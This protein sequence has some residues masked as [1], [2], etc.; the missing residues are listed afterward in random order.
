[1]DGLLRTRMARGA[2][3]QLV[4]KI[5]SSILGLVAFAMM[6]RYL[7]V[8]GFGMYTTVTAFLQFFGILM[9]CGLTLVTIQMISKSNVDENK[10]LSNIMTFRA[11]SAFLFLAAAP[12]IV[13]FFPYPQIVKVGVLVAAASFFFVSLNQIFVSYFQKALRLIVVTIA[14]NVARMI[15]IVG[16]MLAVYFDMGLLNILGWLVVSNLINL[17]V[18]WFWGAKWLK[19]RPA[20]DWII[21][22]EI[23]TRSWPFALSIS[24]NLIYLKGDTIILSLFRP[25]A[26]VGLYGATY[27]V[28][29]ILTMIPTLIMGVA[30]P[31]LVRF[32]QENKKE[33]FVLMQKIFDCFLMLAVPVV[34]GTMLIA[35]KIMVFV[36]GQDF[37]AAGAILR[38]LI[39]AAGA[40]LLNGLSGYAIVALNKQR[41]MIFGY[42]FVAALTLIGY[43]VTI[44]IFGYWGAAWFTVFS[45]TLILILTSI[46]VF[47]TSKFVASFK[48]LPKIL[49]ATIVMLAVLKLTISWP[50]WILFF[51]AVFVYFAILFAVRGLSKRFVFGLIKLR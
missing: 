5:A 30:L 8:E 28:L 7:G 3:I 36:A 19:L 32:W 11:I 42:L 46:V 22:K 44:P 50:V 21:W 20:F 49:L 4:G 33:F 37:F 1:M 10:I 17:A 41:K 24:L 15:L 43:F 16:V 31:V 35:D 51:E 34:L 12:V 26:E 47:K 40:I 45:E 29:D 48:L 27:R 18:S 25:Q 23:W 13:L 6:A 38:V 14:E 2:L 39:L 9:E